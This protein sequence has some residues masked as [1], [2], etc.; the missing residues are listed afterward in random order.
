MN[1]GL[2]VMD[3]AT[4][5][6]R[7]TIADCIPL[8]R[9]AMT[10]LSSGQVEQHLRSFLPVGDGRTFAMMPAVADFGFGAKLI[11]VYQ[12][13]DSPGR[14]R[15]Q[16]L[17]VLFDPETGAPAFIGD[18]EEITRI[19]TAAASAAATDALARP[20]ASV[21]ALVGTG[22]QAQAHL[23]AIAAVRPLTAVRVWGRDAEATQGF[24]EAMQSMFGL[25]VR[26]SASARDAVAEADI[27]CTV[28]ASRDP[29]LNGAW[30][31]PGAHVNLVG[32]SGPHAAEADADLV[33][34]ARFI[35]DHRPHVLAHGGEFLR[36]RDAGR[37]TEDHF[38][39]EIGEVFAGRRPGRISAADVTL[40]KSL[41]HAVQDL[42]AA[43]WL[44]TLERT[45]HHG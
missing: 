34:L 30:V 33:A 3:A 21:L 8:M 31:S 42:A 37:V 29:V 26:A 38:A 9:R 24:A 36:A 7:L 25:E 10:A 12:D 5:R 6:A 40:Y 43:A 2:I 39:A 19:R 41:G 14:R 45:A 11:S 23:E 27:I 13:A 18:A 35:G 28:T 22:A 32:S 4:V 1:D 15:H 44:L 20:D 16:G 17:V